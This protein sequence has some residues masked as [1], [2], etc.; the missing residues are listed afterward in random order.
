MQTDR[1]Q[2]L[3]TLA[4]QWPLLST[5]AI[6]GISR[7]VV[8]AGLI[9]GPLVLPL[10]HLDP[11]PFLAT[12]TLERLLQYDSFYYAGIASHGYDSTGAPLQMSNVV[13]YPLYPML[14]RLFSQISGLSI[15]A[16]LLIIANLAAALAVIALFKLVRRDHDD[17]TA[18]LTVAL[19]SLYPSAMFLSSGYTEP[20]ALMFALSAFLA[21]RSGW[22]WCA[23][24]LI[25]LMLAT[26]STGIILVPVLLYAIWT[27]NRFALRP[28]L[29]QSALMGTLALSGLLAFMAYLWIWHGDPFIFSTGQNAWNNGIHFG[30]RLLNAL[31][32]QPFYNGFSIGTIHLTFTMALLIAGWRLIK[33]D[34]LFYGLVAMLLPYFSL[35]GGTA[36]LTSMARFALMSF[37]ALIV[38]ALLLQ[39]N[40]RYP[41]PAL[42]ISALGLFL[43]SAFFAQ[44]HWI[45]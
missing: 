43:Y 45:G 11:R 41:A 37:P 13:F 4:L 15:H 42:A 29:I 10:R 33:P 38:L 7:L 26:R 20:L 9:I 3:I 12:T 14:A 8:L 6:Y 32:L 23:A 30:E 17:K 36:S 27:S 31:R 16:S 34:L 2:R 21:I 35:A 19:F 5:L 24:L 22:L 18:L 39:R 25:G 28:S 44:S 1:Q 40:P